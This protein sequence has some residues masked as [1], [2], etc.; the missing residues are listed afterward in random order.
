MVTS[1]IQ[2]TNKKEIMIFLKVIVV[3]IGLFA[4]LMVSVMRIVERFIKKNRKTIVKW[5]K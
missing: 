1:P 4:F 3:A 5:R 2:L